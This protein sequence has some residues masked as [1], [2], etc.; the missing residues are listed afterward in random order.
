V[1]SG[2]RM[3]IPGHTCNLAASACVLA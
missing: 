2:L 3:G 1:S